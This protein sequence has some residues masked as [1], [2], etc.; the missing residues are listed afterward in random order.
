MTDDM[1]VT[2]LIWTMLGLSALMAVVAFRGMRGLMRHV[3]AMQAR[4]NAL[5]VEMEM[6]LMELRQRFD[7]YVPHFDALEQRIAGFERLRAEASAPVSGDA[8]VLEAFLPQKSREAAAVA[9]PILVARGLLPRPSPIGG[10]II[11]PGGRSKRVK[12][13]SLH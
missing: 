7:A 6:R 2:V 5:R 13:S 9:A 10:G 8:H 1:V 11:V 3:N 4:L 12:P